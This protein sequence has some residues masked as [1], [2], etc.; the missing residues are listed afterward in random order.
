MNA[1]LV[2]LSLSDLLLLTNQQHKP[3]LASAP[4]DAEAFRQT[5]D[6]VLGRRHWSD[7]ARDPSRR[8]TGGRSFSRRPP[9]LMH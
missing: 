9:L 3:I 2:D 4:I 1:T 8:S 5:I 6:L 7:V